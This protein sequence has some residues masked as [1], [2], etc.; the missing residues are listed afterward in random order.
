MSRQ[1]IGARLRTWVFGR[2]RDLNDRTL[3]HKISLVAVLAWVGLGADGLSSSCYGPEE[4]YKALGAYP[5]LAL[6]IAFA[7][8]GTIAVICASYRQIIELFPTGGGGYLVASKLLGSRAGLVS[9]SALLVD[10]VLTISISVASGGDALFSLLSADYH[11]WKLPFICGGIAF[12]TLIN[13]RGVRESVLMWAPVFFTFLATHAVAI[14]IAIGLH[15]SEFTSVTER[16][17]GQIELAHAEL[18]LGGMFLL[19]LRAFSVGAG[20]YTGI[21]AVSNGLPVLR[22]PQVETGKRTMTLMGLSLAITVFGLLLAYMLV[23]VEPVE[24]KTLNAVLF[25]SI[26]AGW[27]AWLGD[28][29]VLVSLLSATALLFIAA[30][31]GFLD[32][33]RVLA[34]MAQDRWFPSR[35]ATLSDRFVARNGILLMGVAALAVVVVTDGIVGVLVILY[36]INVFLTFTLSQLGM[37]VHWIKVRRPRWRH[38]LLVNGLG[39]IVTSSILVALCAIKFFEGGWITLAATAGIVLLASYVR[40]HYAHSARLIRRLDAD[41]D[42]LTCAERESIALPEP[43]HGR[44]AILL[45]NGFNGLGVRTYFSIFRMFPRTFDRCVFV[46][47]GA[48]DAGSFKGA[49]EIERLRESTDEQMR[50]FVELGRNCGLQ[51]EAASAISTEVYESLLEIVEKLRLTHPDGV[52]FAGQLS[53]QRETFWTRWLHNYIVFAMQRELCRQGVPFVIIP[54]NVDQKAA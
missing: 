3:L 26:T 21:E 31:A 48:V 39:L 40:R 46:H 10:Y 4:T 12:M 41:L 1:S 50:R 54:I 19:L 30:Q 7:C 18:G 11:Q 20:T 28:G 53:F 33:P 15:L 52:V 49:A 44:T 51:A 22:E 14:L 13:L 35:F 17:S 43:G 29:F 38:G 34:N 47:V 8:V 23:N 2:P 25:E 9:G 37:C 42:A 6:F 16:T 45:C 27:P 24:G 32:G 36:S 5:A